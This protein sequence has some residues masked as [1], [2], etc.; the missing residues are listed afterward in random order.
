MWS[1][2]G[3]YDNYLDFSM[4][5]KETPQDY[6]RGSDMGSC[7]RKRV[8]QRLGIKKTEIITKGQRKIMDLGTMYHWHFQGF[9]K[10]TGLQIEKEGELKNEQYHYIGHF[11]SLVGGIPKEI[12]K[13]HFEFIG[14]NNELIFFEE[15]YQYHCKQREQLLE[16]FPDG[17]PKLLYDFKSQHSASFQYIENAPKKEHVAQLRSY[18]YFA[19]ISGI[20]M[21]QD[22]KEGRLLYISKDDMRTVE[23]VVYLTP[24][25]EEEIKAELG[26]LNECYKQDIL[27][28]QLPDIAEGRKNWQCSYC[29]YLTYCKGKDWGKTATKKIT[30]NK[31]T[32]QV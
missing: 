17:L 29:P 3:I 11:D 20:E 4:Q 6:W 18:L 24:E 21:Y 10:K 5:R 8:Y 30:T 12:D 16:M 26:Y 22:I 23:H 14:R 7:P 25:S 2:V 31:K 28:P 1:I 13:K 27:P 9:L 15:T 32:I 19:K